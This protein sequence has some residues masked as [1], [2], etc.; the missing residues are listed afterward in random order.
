VCLHEH[1]MPHHGLAPPSAYRVVRNAD[2]LVNHG[3]TEV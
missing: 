1:Q 2:C 3:A